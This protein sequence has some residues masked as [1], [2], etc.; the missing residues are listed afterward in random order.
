MLLR[1]FISLLAMFFVG[2]ASAQD[3]NFPDRRALIVNLC[4]HVALSD[5][6]Y[7]NFPSSRGERFEQWVTWKNIGVQPI[8]ALE[9][10]ILKFDP[11][12]QAEIGT[13][14]VAEGRNS[15]DWTPLLPGESNRDRSFNYNPERVLTAVAYVRNVRLADGTVWR[16]SDSELQPKL[17]Q[18][19]P[20][21]KDFG[22]LRPATKAQDQ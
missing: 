22:P 21:I 17:R 19:A 10:V 20:W 2:A 15:G 12:D 13:R 1:L 14:I 16:A 18:A 11:F 6:T 5:F 8:V 3:R 4:P 9:V 7:G